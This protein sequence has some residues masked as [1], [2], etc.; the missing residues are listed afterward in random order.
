MGLLKTL[1]KKDNAEKTQV[2]MQEAVTSKPD[3]AKPAADAAAKK[4]KHGE[5]G[6]CCG[7]CQ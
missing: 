3:T 6:V 4:P 7:S 1:F 5:D 2:Q